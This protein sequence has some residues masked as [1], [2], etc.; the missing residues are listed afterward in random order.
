MAEEPPIG[1]VKE[2][3]EDGTVKVNLNQHGIEEVLEKKP[4]AFENWGF[5]GQIKLDDCEGVSPD[6]D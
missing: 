5:V 1:V 4:S 2:V 3:N 6:D